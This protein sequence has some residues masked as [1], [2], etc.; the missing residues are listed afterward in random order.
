MAKKKRIAGKRTVLV[1][2]KSAA[3]K[4][5][6]AVKKKK[7]TKKSFSSPKI[8]TQ[9]LVIHTNDITKIL[10][11][12]IR[13]AQRLLQSIRESLGRNKKDYVSIKEFALYVHLGE[14]EVR[15]NLSETSLN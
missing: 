9:R 8:S 13:T 15:Q 5:K 2:K 11:I 4:K 1:K 7:S 10:G 6:A 3:P 14:E 12:N